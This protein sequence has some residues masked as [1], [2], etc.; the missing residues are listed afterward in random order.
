M[1][2]IDYSRM[3][4]GSPRGARPPDASAARIRDLYKKGTDDIRRA[5][6]AYRIN[7]AYIDMPSQ[8]SQ[9]LYVHSGTGQLVQRPRDTRRVQATIPRV[10]PESRRIMAKLL[11]RPLVFEVAPDAPDG[12]TIRA[13]RTAEAVLTHTSEQHKWNKVREELAWQAWKGGTGALC[14]DWDPSA[15]TELLIDPVTL[16]PVGTGDIRVTTLSIAEIATEVGT[17]D[18]E[19]AAFW[20][21]AQTLPPMEAKRLYNLKNEP[22]ADVNATSTTVRPANGSTKPSALTLVLTYYERPNPDNRTGTVAVV[23]GNEVVDGPH[24][25]P[26]PF[27]DRLNL[28]VARETMVEG[29]WFGKTVVTDVVPM[30]T[31]LNHSWTSALEH[32]KQAGNARLQNSIMERDSAETLTDSPG[33]PVLYNDQPWTYLSPP[34]MPDWWQRVPERLEAAM[35]DALG[36]HDISRGEAPSNIESGLGLSILQE[37][38][39]TPTGKLAQTLADAF[40]DLGTLVLKTYEAKVQP[41]ERRTA[42]ITG[43]IT[44]RVSWDG[45]SFLGQC[46]ARVPYDAVAPI[47]EAGRWAKALALLDRK[48]ISDPRAFSAYVDLPGQASLIEAVNV[49]VAKARRENH[50]MMFG[51]TCIPLIEDNHAIH[52]NE[53]RA[54]MMSGRFE[55][56][57]EATQNRLRLH[58]QAH[59]TLAAEEMGAQALKAEFAP[60]LALAAQ[61]NQP[62]GSAIPDQAS[63]VL[64]Q[65]GV[66]GGLMGGNPDAGPSPVEPVP[67]P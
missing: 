29:Q 48:V 40:S 25:W 5:Q 54:E 9:W 14:L 56:A 43:P 26:F 21:K 66:M 33:D 52:I 34:S 4:E 13:A 39:D 63:Q 15:G 23:I 11:R 65:S 50:E 61:A 19:R 1:T 53:H 37:Q 47:S 44:E 17:R 27:T 45:T 58:M 51:E 59:A 28:V 32:M 55:R 46:Y 42:R 6:L 10:G 22:V 3:N 30:Q 12:A 38:D 24:P 8:D 57:D 67:N 16:R 60:P 20:I 41:P 2:L 7:A 49:D 31:A 35:D 18:I 64:P 36:V 62:P